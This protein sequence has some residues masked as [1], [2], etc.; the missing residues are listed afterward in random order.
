MFGYAC[1][2][3]TELMPLPISLATGWS[4]PERS[5]QGMRGSLSPPDSKSQVTVKYSNGRPSF[6]TAVVLSTQHADGIDINTLMRP[7]LIEHVIK[8]VLPEGLYDPEFRETK[9]F[10]NPT[11]KFVIGGPMGDT[12]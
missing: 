9:L 10:V 8:P 7:D 5:A 2:D 6:V 4:T 12:V 1:R 3:C 11:G